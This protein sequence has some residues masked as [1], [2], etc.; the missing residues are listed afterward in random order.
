[1]PDVSMLTPDAYE[2]LLS[3]LQSVRGRIAGAAQ[4]AGR[5]ADEIT[6]IAVT[7]TIPA[8][9]VQAAYGA[10]ARSFGENR[11]QE[12]RDKL[13]RLTLPES[14]WELIGSLQRNKATKAVELF[15]RVQSVDSLELAQALDRAAALRQ[16]VMPVLVQ[17]NVAGEATKHGVAPEVALPLARAIATLPNLRGEG[18]MTVAPYVADPPMA[19]PV[20]RR[21]RELRDLLRQEVGSS[22]RELSMG[23]TNDYPIAIAEGATLV[24]IGRAI[25][26]ERV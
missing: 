24:R 26:G 9:L 23:M 1:M 5:Q 14:R 20:F 25:F 19:R 10:G 18:L 4:A 8:A 7:K 6:L 2:R 17:V 3:N 21:L 12:A 11:V 16:C 15:T 13:A 22:W